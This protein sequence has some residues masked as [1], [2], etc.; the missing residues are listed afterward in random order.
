M[1]KQIKTFEDL[2]KE[3]ENLK[4][5]IAIQRGN[6]QYDIAGIKNALKPAS[7]AYGM[8]GKYVNTKP[9]S[10]ALVMATKLITAFILGKINKKR[11]GGI[12]RKISALLLA[13]FV[14]LSVR[15]LVV[16]VNNF[17]MSKFRRP[18]AKVAPSNIVTVEQPY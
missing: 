12:I 18:V 8:F 1:D 3:K 5:Q 15:P 11:K 16:A 7:V 10:P 6:I 2:L 4:H 9:N 14:T 17:L 13:N